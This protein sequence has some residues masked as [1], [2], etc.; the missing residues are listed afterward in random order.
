MAKSTFNIQQ[1]RGNPLRQNG[2]GESTL[3]TKQRK[4]AKSQLGVLE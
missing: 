1:V 2:L 4:E 3:E